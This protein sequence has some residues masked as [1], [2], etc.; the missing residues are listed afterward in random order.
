MNI[1]YKTRLERL[2][3]NTKK[4]RAVRCA[5]FLIDT[6]LTRR[7]E[8]VRNVHCCPNGEKIC[9]HVAISTTE[10]VQTVV[11]QTTVVQHSI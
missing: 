5:L 1:I 7:H 6:E 10:E 11:Q 9:A 2:R 4:Q 8:K 3:R